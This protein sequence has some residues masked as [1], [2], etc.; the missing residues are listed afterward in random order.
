MRNPNYVWRLSSKEIFKKGDWFYLDKNG[1]PIK[2]KSQEVI[3]I[4][5]GVEVKKFKKLNSIMG[6]ISCTGLYRLYYK[7]L[8]LI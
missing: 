8:I 1:I 4:K 6:K 5:L 2:L 3:N 7:E